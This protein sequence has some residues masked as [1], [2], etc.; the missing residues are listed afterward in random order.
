MT[1]T[2]C[3]AGGSSRRFVAGNFAFLISISV[4]ALV[5]LSI[6]PMGAK[7]AE[8]SNISTPWTVSVTPFD[9]ISDGSR[10][11]I[12]LQTDSAHL[13]SSAK[14]QVCRSGVN[15][16]TSTSFVPNDDFRIGGANCPSVPI[17]T[18]GDLA[19]QA[20]NTYT[21]AVRPGGDTFTFAAGV[22]TVAWNDTNG[23]AK[24]L[25]CDAQ[26][27]CDL[28][29]QVRGIGSDGIL[30]WIPYTQRLTYRIDDPIAGCGG[31]AKGLVSSASSERNTRLWVDLT[32]AQCKSPG[33]QAGAL[34]SSSF[35]GEGSAL[36]MYSG[37]DVD[38]VYSSVVY[39]SASGFGR[40]DSSDPLTPRESAL[41]PVALNAT[42]LAVGNGYQ[43]ANGDKL[44]YSNVKLTLDEVAAL[45]SGGPD[46][47]NSYLSAIYARNPQLQGTGMFSTSSSIRLGA[48]PDK[49]ST[50]WYST[51]ILDSLRP[52]LWKV[53]NTGTFGIDAGRDRTVV[54]SFALADPSFQGVL[55]LFTGT[56][57]LD[58]TI[59]TLGNGDFGGVWAVTDLATAR[60]LDM[61]VV[62]I[63]N[64]AG[65]FVEPT[66]ASMLAAVSSMT[67][68][69]DGR[70]VPNYSAA[71]VQNVEP[72][73]L[74]FVEYAVAPLK[75]LVDDRCNPRPT[76]Q[77]LLTNWLTYVTQD[78]QQILPDGLEAITSS[79]AQTAV[80][81]ISRVGT[82]ANTC[83]P[84]PDVPSD[85]V[86]S[87]G[88]TSVSPPS[89]LTSRFGSSAARVAPVGSTVA[90]DA[91]LA[92]V[93]AEMP[94]FVRRSVG[95][96]ALALVGLAAVL[97]LLTVSAMATSGR[98]SLSRFGRSG[99]RS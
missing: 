45:L 81:Q 92:S 19:A 55:N 90:V 17:S 3:S 7:R 78:G 10:I 24:S 56:S 60:S 99:R 34:S 22:G 32:V 80:T 70:L 18:S 93:Q 58:K 85:S 51:G 66:Q 88:V 87:G 52:N 16:G 4:V 48:A 97:G 11:R 94:D 44:P 79:M 41:V 61:T 74:T 77:E 31:P 8:A 89:A 83:I 72:Y 54:T 76:S 75:P 69:S 36:E 91:Q 67:T 13:I 71:A 37:S 38:F 40:G 21:N 33:S 82:V 35:A 50:T 27:P 64:A 12:N 15:Y 62:Q 57:I 95:T 29:V 6:L 86:N 96:N 73:P 98:L 23:A 25:T 28:V 42:V 26:N 9:E 43:G 47:I 39:D 49:E 53:P 68:A 2:P 1:D 20:S 5:V 63:E 46:Q 14:A 65:A 84:I 59:K 30:R